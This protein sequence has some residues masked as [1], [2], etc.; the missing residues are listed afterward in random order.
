MLI[1]MKDFMDDLRSI[2]REKINAADAAA[3]DA[4]KKRN[5]YDKIMKEEYSRG[6]HYREVLNMLDE[7]HQKYYDASKEAQKRNDITQVNS[8]QNTVTD[9]TTITTAYNTA[10]ANE[11]V[12]VDGN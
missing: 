8:D 3:Y 10:R 11:E 5:E 4:E 1:N 12:R 6:R 7:I 9:P 2:L